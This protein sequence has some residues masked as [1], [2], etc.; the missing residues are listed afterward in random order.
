MTAQVNQTFSLNT[1]DQ[2]FNNMNQTS[3]QITQNLGG[4]QS[5]VQL[6]NPNQYSQNQT[7][8]QNSSVLRSMTNTFQNQ[9]QDL[10]SDSSQIINNNDFFQQNQSS[11]NFKKQLKYSTDNNNIYYEQQKAST[12]QDLNANNLSNPN[13]QLTYDN[14]N[15]S[16]DTKVQLNFGSAPKQSQSL[17]PFQNSNCVNAI[18]MDTGAGSIIQQSQSN[19]IKPIINR[20]D[21]KVK[22]PI[23]IVNTNNNIQMLQQQHIRERSDNNT[24]NKSL[25]CSD[26]IESLKIKPLQKHQ[27]HKVDHSVVSTNEYE[28]LIMKEN[29]KSELTVISSSTAK[30][31]TNT[32]VSTYET[33]K[34]QELL[35][36][37]N[38]SNLFQLQL[39][40]HEISIQIPHSI[41]LIISCQ[42]NDIKY[43]TPK[44]RK[45][46]QSTQQVEF[47]DQEIFINLLPN[48]GQQQQSIRDNQTLSIKLMAVSDTKSKLI[49]LYQYKFNL[50]S[51]LNL[52]KQKFTFDKCID[53]QATLILSASLKGAY[54]K[55][56]DSQIQQQQF[57]STSRNDRQNSL[58]NNNSSKSYSVI[59]NNRS[60][61]HTQSL[62]M[63]H[64]PRYQPTVTQTPLPER[65]CSESEF[66]MSTMKNQ[67]N[68][69]S[70]LK[71]S[72]LKPLR[73]NIHHT[74][75]QSNMSRVLNESNIG[76]DD[77][78]NLI[79]KEDFEEGKSKDIVTARATPIKSNA[80]ARKNLSTARKL[81]HN[82][83]SPNINIRS[84]NNNFQ[85]ST[86]SA[87]GGV[88]LQIINGA[89]GLGQKLMSQ[90]YNLTQG[91]HENNNNNLTST[92][93]V[94][95]IGNNLDADTLITERRDTNSFN[96]TAN[97]TNMQAYNAAQAQLQQS[98]NPPSRQ[99]NAP[100]V[101]LRQTPIKNN[102]QSQ[103]LAGTTK[104]THIQK[105]NSISISGITHQQD[106]QQ[107]KPP[108]TPSSFQ[109][110][111]ESIYSLRL[112][113]LQFNT[114]SRA[115]KD[116]NIQPIKKTHRDRQEQEEQNQYKI[117]ELERKLSL[118]DNL[119]SQLQS[120]LQV[121]KQEKQFILEKA[122]KEQQN[123]EETTKILRQEQDKSQL[124]MKQRDQ[125]DADV[126]YL[127]KQIEQMR[128]QQVQE[129]SQ[130]HH[131]N[132]S[133][134]Y[135]KDEQ[136]HNQSI[137]QR[138]RPQTAQVNN[139]QQQQIKQLEAQVIVLQ[140][141]NEQLLSQIDDSQLK[142]NR[143]KQVA[144]L[145][146][147]KYQDALKEIEQLQSQASLHQR[148]TSQKQNQ[149]DVQTRL[150]QEF[151]T[152][153][154]HLTKDHQDH[155][156]DQNRK[157]RELQKQV[158][159]LVTEQN[160]R[161]LELSE[162]REKLRKREDEV[163]ELKTNLNSQITGVSD[164]YHQQIEEITA[165]NTKLK[166]D[167]ES[168]SQKYG[169]ERK[170]RVTADEEKQDI[171]ERYERQR[172]MMKENAKDS[173]D[174]QSQVANLE[175]KLMMT[176]QQLIQVKASWA[177]SEHEK[178]QLYN[179][180]QENL[181]KVQD[182]EEKLQEQQDQFALKLKGS[183]LERGRRQSSVATTKTGSS[184]Q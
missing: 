61:H 132:D 81:T 126:Q 183:D 166:S 11:S 180:C 116:D 179:E 21:L 136:V 85:E 10:N 96:D 65:H 42:H 161:E 2:N 165:Q 137:T 160:Q 39:T 40:V 83:Q 19:T 122:D 95:I 140:Q 176:E 56:S 164:Q 159:F 103:K 49:G 131:N 157:R 20:R 37:I 68:I 142:L 178:A 72:S 29:A 177:E 154:D 50:K 94:Q 51:F 173:I 147:G 158:D 75:Q 41:N 170:A 69:N 3:S 64:L 149:F 74:N 86:P 134:N 79:N 128:I 8:I 44:R 46:N 124:F 153:I 6:Q 7:S 168:M 106:K 114:E 100:M 23:N 111:C 175:E 78:C 91:S 17:D 127:Q 32:R 144:D 184:I 97:Q 163:K 88:Y 57:I 77:E 63:K 70:N 117:E 162:C 76:E 12:N 35:E 1:N 58:T 123:R 90:T 60:L 99:S 14:T 141:Q 71:D 120:E 47:G 38:S 118:Q 54:P 25:L 4:K 115:G 169:V 145:F 22:S 110:I 138:N 113:A 171:Q 108:Q 130:I 28:G 27:S 167:L 107:Q 133:L 92:P 9:Q 148:Q 98:S 181:E 45:I 93:Q 139:Q 26:N 101:Y 135:S 73:A 102:R 31:S 24:A 143:Q 43:E 150:T 36:N 82:L 151:Q 125:L 13:R 34:N 16:R 129:K 89:M 174:L 172:E 156:E 55:Q 105:S 33:P 121:L 80:L 67:I 155:R 62:Q 119:V 146:E 18:S 48:G 109:Q 182:L 30:R 15:S 52:Q 66:F 87:A 59:E 84:L 53:K 104:H 5:S 152:K 112:G